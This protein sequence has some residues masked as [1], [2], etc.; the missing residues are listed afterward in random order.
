MMGGLFGG[1]SPPPPPRQEIVPEPKPPAPMPDPQSYAIRE[2]QRRE[3][4]KIRDRVGRRGTIL[5]S[6]L[7]HSK[8]D[9]G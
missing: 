2:A 4:M 9:L 7:G 3:R 6:P 1:D 8:Q 5:T